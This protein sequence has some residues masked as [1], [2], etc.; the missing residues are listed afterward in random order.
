MSMSMEAQKKLF[1]EG[2]K[3]FFAWFLKR[4]RQCALI[5]AGVFLS[6]L[7]FEIGVLFERGRGHEALV[8]EK[9]LESVAQARENTV[10]MLPEQGDARVAGAE[11]TN[12]DSQKNGKLSTTQQGACLFVGSKNSV[13]YHSPSCSYAKRIKPEN[14]VCFSSKEEAEKRG[15]VAGCIQ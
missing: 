13:K 10:A 8:V 4:E 15:Y 3:R 12:K 5:A 14:R 6:V 9:P 2:K 11:M 7:S 1:T